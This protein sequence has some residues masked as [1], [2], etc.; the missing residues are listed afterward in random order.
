MGEGETT[1]IVATNQW[2]T[3]DE[4]SRFDQINKYFYYKI[5]FKYR[6]NE[7]I[8]IPKLVNRIKDRHER[9]KPSIKWIQ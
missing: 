2:R 1:P 9:Y 4:D 3:S 5:H 7:T 8:K 6:F